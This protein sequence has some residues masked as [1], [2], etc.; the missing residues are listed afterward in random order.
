MKLFNKLKKQIGVIALSIIAII[1]VP[2][3]AYANVLDGL[4]SAKN[5][6]LAQAKPVVNSII[7]PIALIFLGGWLVFSIVKAVVRYRHG[8]DL[9]LGGCILILAGAIFVATFPA[10][11]WT[12]M[13]V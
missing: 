8:Q 9:E 7:V 2:I 3:F 6:F 13:G 4:T 11:G 1:Q 12:A 5:G 10:W